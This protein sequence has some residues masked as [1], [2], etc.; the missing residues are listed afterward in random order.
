MRGTLVTMQL[1]QLIATPWERHKHS[2]WY[3]S[4]SLYGAFQSHNWKITWSSSMCDTLFLSRKRLRNRLEISRRT[5][6]CSGGTYCWSSTR[7]HSTWATSCKAIILLLSI[8]NHYVA[9]SLLFKLPKR[10]YRLEVATNV[11]WQRGRRSVW[12]RWSKLV[13]FQV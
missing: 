10:Q 2:P 12:E 4:R 11:V 3:R 7:H 9:D 8:L 6:K 13:K 5:S 1:R